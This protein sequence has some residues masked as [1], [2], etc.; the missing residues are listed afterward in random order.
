MGI[1]ILILENT[2]QPAAAALSGAFG[3]GFPNPIYFQNSE[4]N[5]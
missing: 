1:M 5:A 3:L 2:V 4:D